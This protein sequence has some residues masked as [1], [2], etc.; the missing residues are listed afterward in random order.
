MYEHHNHK[1][2]HFNSEEAFTFSTCI[3]HLL[4]EKVRAIWKAAVVEEEGERK[5]CPGEKSN[6]EKQKEIINR[7]QR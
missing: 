1:E 3:E 5:T 6:G 2:K 4:G 7:R